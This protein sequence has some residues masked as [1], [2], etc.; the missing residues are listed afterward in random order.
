LTEAFTELGV[1]FEV[2]HPDIAVS[3]NFGGSSVL[4]QQIEAG[5]AA[6]VFASADEATMRTLSKTGKVTTPRL[7]ARNRLAILVERGNPKA[8]RG[9]ADLSRPGLEVVL[10]APEVP[11]GR[12]T[13]TALAKA[14]AAVRPAAREENVKAVVSKVVLGEADAGIVYASDVRAVGDKAEGV[15]IDSAGDPDLE[16]IYP[17]AA[18]NSGNRQAA[19]AWIEHVLSERG[20][21]TLHSYGF[22]SP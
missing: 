5:A 20:Q 21:A 3:F 18:V 17:I 7:I 8:I 14:G 1:T 6:D 13:E 12:L 15:A 2:S 22:L 10:C 11:C 4:V 9:L 19:G 16:A